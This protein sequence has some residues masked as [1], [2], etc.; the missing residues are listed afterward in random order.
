M[1]NLPDS[2]DWLPTPLSSLGAV[3][4]ALRCQVCKDFFTTP[5]LTSCAHTFCSACIR[6]CVAADARCPACRAPEQEVKL[7]W[8]GAVQEAV[9]AFVAAREGVLGFARQA[10]TPSRKRRRDEADGA[11]PARKTRSQSRRDHAVAASQEE[12]VTAVDEASDDG[13]YTPGMD[14]VMAAPSANVQTTASCPVRCAI[15]A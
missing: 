5:M 3:E 14:L 13:D 4:S 10:L 12:A 15:S 11:E 9:D 1:D 6:R 8:N 2:T 7:R